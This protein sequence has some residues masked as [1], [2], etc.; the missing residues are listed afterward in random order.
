L[1]ENTRFTVRMGRAVLKLKHAER[2]GDT[3]SAVTAEE[4]LR[5]VCREYPHLAI[6][7]GLSG[8]ALIPSFTVLRCGA[9]R[10]E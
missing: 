1:F 2:T 10:D 7:A 9:E 4:E 6:K 3:G 5:K 8:Y